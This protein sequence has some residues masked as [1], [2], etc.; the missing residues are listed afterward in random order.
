MNFIEMS[1]EVEKGKLMQLPDW[2]DKNIR[3]RY[4]NEYCD[5]THINKPSSYMEIGSTELHQHRVSK[6]KYFVQE[7]YNY[8]NPT[9][10]QISRTDWL[11]YMGKGKVIPYEDVSPKEDIYEVNDDLVFNEEHR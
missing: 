11:E 10:S 5:G 4:S 7:N 9:F 3:R 8:Y 2:G 6:D 1:A